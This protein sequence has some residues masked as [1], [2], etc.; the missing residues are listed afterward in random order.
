MRHIEDLKMKIDKPT[1]VVDIMT[2]LVQNLNPLDLER[3]LET[4]TERKQIQKEIMLRRYGISVCLE[5][6]LYLCLQKKT[7]LLYLKHKLLTKK[8]MILYMILLTMKMKTLAY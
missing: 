6:L 4:D 3:K 2:I 8:Q 5:N 1:F 7:T